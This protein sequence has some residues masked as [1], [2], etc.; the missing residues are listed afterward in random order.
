MATEGYALIT[1]QT[2]N[3]SGNK[4]SFGGSKGLVLEQTKSSAQVFWWSCK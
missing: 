3:N 4:T 1:A 2:V